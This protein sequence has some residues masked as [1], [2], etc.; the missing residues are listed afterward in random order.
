MGQRLL[1][2]ASLGKTYRRQI[3]IWK[4]APHRLLTGTCKS[5]DKVPLYTYCKSQTQNSE[6]SQCWWGCGGQ[7]LSFI[8]GGMQTGTDT[9]ETALQFL[10]EGNMFLSHGRQSCS[11]LFTQRRWK[12]L[13][14][15]KPAHGCLQQLR[16]LTTRAWEQPR[17]A[18]EGD[19]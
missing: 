13:S 16:F 19:G 2:N 1:T 10:T 8:A 14:A 11:L 17:C 5:Q 7:K 12:L 4:D 15:Q 6:T 9:L 3:S 18:S